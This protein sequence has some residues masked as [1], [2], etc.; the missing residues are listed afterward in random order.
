MTHRRERLHREATHVLQH[1]DTRLAL[2]AARV[3]AAD[4]Q[5]VLARGFSLTRRASDGTVVRDPGALVAGEEL[6]TET[7]QGSVRSTVLGDG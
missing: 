1:A 7:A 5:R 4:P 6:I 3:D 2:A